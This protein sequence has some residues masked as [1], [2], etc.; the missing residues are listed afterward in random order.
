MVMGN[1]Y[2]YIEGRWMRGKTRKQINEWFFRKNE[3]GGNWGGRRVCL[4]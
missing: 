1:K 4:L 3:R 2:V